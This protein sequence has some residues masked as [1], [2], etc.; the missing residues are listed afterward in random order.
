MNQPNRMR[1]PFGIV[2]LPAIAAIMILVYYYTYHKPQL[3]DLR[4]Q[5][6]A[7]PIT[8][9]VEELVQRYENSESPNKI[10]KNALVR[11]T[12]TVYQTERSALWGE[13]VVVLKQKDAGW[14][15]VVLQCFLDTDNK[16]KLKGIEKGQQITIT[17]IVEQQILQVIILQECSIE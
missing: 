5:A 16:H 15:S 3:A 10:S 7:D 14:S 2:W 11:V 4:A 8:V 13:Y 17:G 1:N 12:G 6:E 9:T